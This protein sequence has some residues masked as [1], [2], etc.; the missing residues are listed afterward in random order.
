MKKVNEKFYCKRVY[1]IDDGGHPYLRVR[2]FWRAWI[3]LWSALYLPA[4]YGV[5][6][7]L[8]VIAAE[9]Y[10]TT[11]FRCDYAIDE[12]GYLICQRSGE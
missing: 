7:K 3:A 1:A 11:G 2:W 12:E 10:K 9:F 5:L 6:T 8:S 4:I